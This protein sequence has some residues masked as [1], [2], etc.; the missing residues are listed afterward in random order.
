MATREKHLHG[1]AIGDVISFA[2]VMSFDGRP[3]AED[4]SLEQP[5][6]SHSGM[7]ILRIQPQPIYSRQLNH[8]DVVVVDGLLCSR[9]DYT[10]FKKLQQEVTWTYRMANSHCRGSRL[11]GCEIYRQLLCRMC[12]FFQIDFITAHL[13]YYPLA[14]SHRPYHHDAHHRYQHL[15]Q[16]ITVIGSFGDDRTLNFKCVA[17]QAVTPFLLKNGSVLLFGKHV[18]AAYVHG[19]E[20]EPDKFV[21]GRISISLWGKL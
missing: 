20:P 10:L 19:L 15:P 4:L 1:F 7:R 5:V 13:N 11:Q 14:P 8:G 9:D 21:Q 6:Q 2:L 17:T 3:K 12:A 18:N 16:N